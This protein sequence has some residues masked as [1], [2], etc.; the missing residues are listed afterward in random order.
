MLLNPPSFLPGTYRLAQKNFEQHKI[1]TINNTVF[2]GS[3]Y[4][5]LNKAYFGSDLSK[6]GISF[7]IK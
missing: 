4:K 5:K 7:S 1:N 3:K 2:E 6:S